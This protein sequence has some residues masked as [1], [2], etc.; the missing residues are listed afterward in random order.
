[1]VKCRAY[2]TDLL[3]RYI[4]ESGLRIGFIVEQMGISRQAFDKKRKGEVLFRLPEIYLLCDILGIRDEETK[5][6]I[7]YP[8]S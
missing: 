5:R 3:N 1:M 2:D 7:F 4:D 8:E 6:K